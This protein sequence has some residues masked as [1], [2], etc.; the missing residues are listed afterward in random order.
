LLAFRY[1]ATGRA[2]WPAPVDLGAARDV[3]RGA[4]RPEA[5][6]A[7]DGEVRIQ[8]AK[9]ILATGATSVVVDSAGRVP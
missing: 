9:G 3:P 2:S 1:D 4:E 5:T 7:A 6:S 8:V